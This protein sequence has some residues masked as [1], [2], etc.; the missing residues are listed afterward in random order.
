[1]RHI[2]RSLLGLEQVLVPHGVGRDEYHETGG[3]GESGNARALVVG[4]PSP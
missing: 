1:V 4:G 2:G 3:R